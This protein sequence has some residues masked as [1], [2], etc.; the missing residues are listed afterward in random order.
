MKNR[1]KTREKFRV[2]KSIQQS[3]PV[4][5]IYKDGVWQIGDGSY[6]K[7]WLFTDI[8]YSVA[9]KDDQLRMFMDYCA[10]HNALSADSVTKISVNN[11]RLNP[12]E[13]QQLVLMDLQNDT[14]DYLRKE[15]ND[16]VTGKAESC[17][18]IVREKYVTVTVE[19]KN[20]AEA[21]SYFTRV[22]NDLVSNLARLSSKCEELTNAE[23]LR[24]LHDFFRPGEEQHFRFDLSAAMRLG[25]DFRDYICPDGLQFKA[26]H[27]EVGSKFGRVLFLKE[28]PAFLKDTLIAELT[29]F[30]RQMMLSMDILPIPTDEAVKEMQK[31]ILAVETDITR[32]QQKQN[33]NN[34]FSVEP[35]Y[36][37][38]QM[39]AETK[40]FLD[41]L[42][43]R[44]QRMV[45]CM[46]SL[47]HIADT[48]EQLDADTDT[49]LATGRK[50]L[51]QF[52]VL[53]YQQEDGLNTVL[54][55]GLLRLE[56]TRTLTTESTAV[57]MPFS[58]QEI[59]DTGG[60]YYGQNAVSRNLIICNR[61]NL[62]NGNGLILGVSG[63][64]KSLAAKMEMLFI[65]LNSKDHVIIVDPE[66]EYGPLIQAVS[67]QCVF[68]SASSENHINAMAI[69]ADYADGESPIALKSEFVMTLCEQLM[70]HGKLGP[71]EKS[72]IDRCT[73][74]VYKDYIKRFSGTP[75]TLS[76]LYRELLQQED[77][78]AREIA[79]TL[80]LFTSGSL[81]V[82]AHQT[83]VDMDNRVMLY[84]ILDLG[85][86]LRTT[87]MLVMLDA[88]MLRVSENFKKG[89]R[90]HV[91][92]DELHLFF[93]QGNEYTQNFLSGA[94]KR[95]R[96]RNSVM[97]GI[98]Q[99]LEDML[100]SHVARTMMAN[101]EFLLML[102]QAPT[103]RMELA[104]LLNISETQLSY[105]TNAE[106]GH[107]LIKVG[108]SLVP[109][110]NEVDRSTETYRLISTKPGGG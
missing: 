82:F 27:F 71:K 83:N 20:V 16:M 101:S 88:I 66:R 4:K 32:W 89:I 56:G 96:K 49:L 21:R 80:E 2:P 33:A 93:G 9:S 31:R 109:F 39:R 87:A 14:L 104:K 5:R 61:A 95:M 37:L 17:N 44:D 105:I 97:T 26:D 53:R 99:N 68:L 13:F 84:D 85:P 48:K 15:A 10:L 90:T 59:M 75:P 60:I 22:G 100:Q 58:A 92:V 94:W 63:S 29:E 73:A 12:A 55:Y 86:Q 23:R 67:G 62:L 38:Q 81:N 78:E 51:C 98:T 103:D 36:E 35:P 1:T 106:A 72:I 52:A 108:A 45:F 7:T 30:P 25:H 43:T 41:D 28:Y 91:F 107:G 110:V 8:N 6:S 42:T 76:D 18:N 24:I 102:N 65:M 47:V 74:I 3:I 57:L 40:E 69:S 11:R 34:N 79:L 46:L 50:H 70:G 19:K 64:G 77:P 54:P